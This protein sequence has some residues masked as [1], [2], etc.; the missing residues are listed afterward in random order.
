MSKQL[1]EFQLADHSKVILETDSSGSQRIAN[2]SD[3]VIKAQERFEAVA[4]RIR[5]A[6]QA[7]LDALKEM[8]TPKEIE[9]EFGLKFS[10][11]AG[12]IIANANSE[13]NFK[14]RVLWEN[15]GAE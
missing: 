11:T 1:V 7:V 2:S 15:A 13:V 10:A 6:A 8:N 4:A 9:L 12:V 3:G 14:V 5:P